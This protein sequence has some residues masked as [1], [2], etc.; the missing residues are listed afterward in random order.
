MSV[1]AAA[2]L[3]GAPRPAAVTVAD[4]AGQ[5]ALAVRNGSLQQPTATDLSLARQKADA[6]RLWQELQ[7][8]GLS[9]Q[10]AADQVAAAHVER[11]PLLVS[12]G[13]GGGSMLAGGFRALCNLRTWKNRLRDAS[14]AVCCE[15]AA[16]LVRDYAKGRRERKG[17]PRFWAVLGSLYLSRNGPHLPEA[18]QTALRECRRQ[19]MAGLPSLSQVRYWYGH[20]VDP[21]AISLARNG[22]KELGARFQY[23]IRRDWDAVMVNDIWFGDHHELDAP[24]RIWDEAEQEWRA[25]RCT[26][27]AWL[28]ARSLYFTGWQIAPGSGNSDRIQTSLAL[29]MI[30]AGMIAPRYLYVD[31]GADYRAQGF[32][33]PIEVGG[34]EH[35]VLRQLGIETLHS[36][37]YRAQAKVIERVF[38]IVCESFSRQW[39]G[40]RGCSPAARTE[41]SDYFWEHPEFL[42][43]VDEL[44]AGF[45]RWLAEVYHLRPSAGCILQGKSPQET[46]EARRDVRAPWSPGDL[47]RAFLVPVGLRL[48][49]RGPAV[50]LEGKHY[51]SEALWPFCG[52]K[53]D[54][55]KVLVKVDRYD[56]EHVLCFHGDGRP[57]CEARTRERVAALALT[58]EERAKIGD[59]ERLKHAQRNRAYTALAV[60]TGGTYRLADPRDRIRML[61]DDLPVNAI[62]RVGGRRSVKGGS[63][64]FTHCVLPDDS[65][66]GEP[67]SGVSCEPESDDLGTLPPAAPD[68]PAV[69]P[70][71][72]EFRACGQSRAAADLAAVH[73]TIVVATVPAIDDDQDEVAVVVSAAMLAQGDQDE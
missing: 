68:V 54:Q 33:Q 56:R 48:V 52:A 57:V 72:I 35:S 59:A 27:T 41:K 62:E 6:V 53:G 67:A 22:E 8:D 61:M 40:Y 34:H 71:V 16:A 5:T 7:R 11:F 49:G 10:A 45:A 31:R 24:A 70:G 69:T 15:N 1:P 28:D 42:P 9:Q 39:V 23:F 51:Y 18:Y 21:A 32:D 3:P 19:G 47:Y 25:T 60:E 50:T 44:S 36:L 65:R 73:A 46:W 66:P 63:H 55:G 2:A 58:P 17:D 12:A 20:C 4:F 64:R 26:L 37:P 13:K 38:G 14:G 43:T 29:G 30:V